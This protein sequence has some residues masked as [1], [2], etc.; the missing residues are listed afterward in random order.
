MNDILKKSVCDILDSSGVDLRNA[1]DVRFRDL[2]LVEPAAED[3]QLPTR[4]LPRFRKAFG[5]AMTPIL[6]TTN[7][8]RRFLRRCLKGE[9]PK[10]KNQ[11]TMWGKVTPSSVTEL[12]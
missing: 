11:R 8:K 3:Y 6:I 12:L 9:E 4:P 10:P 5:P 2:K 1:L 7:L